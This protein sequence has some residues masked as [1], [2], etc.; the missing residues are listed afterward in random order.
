MGRPGSRGETSYS[1]TCV[2]FF[3]SILKIP[4]AYLNFLK[5][6]VSVFIF[7]IHCVLFYLIKPCH[8]EAGRRLGKEPGPAHWTQSQMFKL[9]LQDSWG[10]LARFQPLLVHRQSKC[11]KDLP[12][13]SSFGIL[14]WLCLEKPRWENSQ[15]QSLKCKRAPLLAITLETS[16]LNKVIWSTLGKQRNSTITA[17]AEEE[18]LFGTVVTC[19]LM[20]QSPMSWICDYFIWVSR[21]IYSNG[22]QVSLSKWLISTLLAHI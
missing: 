1:H 10:L 15:K 22:S 5:I 18:R 3:S 6:F 21:H 8:P 14:H 20:Y 12:F 11:F 16:C 4:G 17:F 7:L 19:P 9:S 2:H 13:F